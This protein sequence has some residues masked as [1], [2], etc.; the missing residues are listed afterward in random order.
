MG[1][2]DRR[3]TPHWSRTRTALLLGTGT[4]ISYGI[5]SSDARY[6]AKKA[7]D[8]FINGG[9]E[10]P[11]PPTST[12]GTGAASGG[13]STPGEGISEYVTLP[14]L[15]IVGTLVLLLALYATRPQSQVSH[16]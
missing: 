7:L 8:K 9:D 12:G 5:F 2:P 13:G 10:P 6:M 3:R 15:A 16:A 1:R 14:N 4:L 11:L